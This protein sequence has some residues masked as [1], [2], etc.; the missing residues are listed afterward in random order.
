MTTAWWSDEK[1]DATVTAEY[2]SRELQTDANQAALHRPLAFGDGLTDDTYLDWILQ[3]GR[4]IFLILNHI[5]CPQCIFEIIDKTFDDDDL[6]LSEEALWEL[7]LFGGKSET[8]DKKFYRQQFNFMV[9]EFQPGGHV[10][11]GDDD[12]LPLEGFF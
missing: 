5:G 2:V 4:R 9:Q 12:V 11:Y 7:N 1:I 3:R 8:L 6:P 10:D